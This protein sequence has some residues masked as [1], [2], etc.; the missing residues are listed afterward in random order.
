VS[1]SIKRIL[2]AVDF[3]E[4]SDKAFDYAMSL[5]RVFEAEVVALHV[6]HDPIV[7]A[8]TTGQEWRDEFERTI[9]EKL[10]ALLNRHTCE[11]V[12]VTA[13]IKQGGAWLE[14]IEYAKAE[15]CD[16]I[17]LG[18]H[19][20]GPVQHTLMGSVAEKVVRKAKHPVLVVRPDQHHFVMP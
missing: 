5:A 10:D 1:L 7:Y 9:K 19:G 2:A 18:T 8:P 6:V 4:T 16:M 13:V 11:G 17:V 15:N 14:I 3:S 20:H 12:E